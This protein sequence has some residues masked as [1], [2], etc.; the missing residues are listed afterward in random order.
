MVNHIHKISGL[1]MD[2]LCFMTYI[3]L[4]PYIINFSIAVLLINVETL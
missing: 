3:Q 4:K 2:S 1:V